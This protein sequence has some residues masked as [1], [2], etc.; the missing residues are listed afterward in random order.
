LRIS[1]DYTLYCREIEPAE[2]DNFQDEPLN[3]ASL[4]LDD[5][6]RLLFFHLRLFLRHEKSKALLH[7]PG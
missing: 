3:F 4:G 7:E 1:D 6:R 5:Q 2:P